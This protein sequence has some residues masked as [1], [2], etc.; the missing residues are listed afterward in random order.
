MERLRLVVACANGR[1]RTSMSEVLT[2][3]GHI[4]VGEAG[5][6]TST[7]VLTRNVRPDVVLLG[8][9][10][11]GEGGPAVA[12]ELLARNLAALVVLTDKQ[13]LPCA[14]NLVS[15][16]VSGCLLKPVS[17]EGL[18]FTIAIAARK[19]NELTQLTQ[20]AHIAERRLANRQLVEKAKGV[21][22]QREGV[23]EDEAYGQLRRLSMQT[24]RDLGTVAQ[25]VL[26]NESL[27]ME[28]SISCK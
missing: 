4:V 22:M 18:A 16:G 26:M 23:C 13:T 7:L 5:D 14:R 6:G 21:L 2:R 12:R 17:P 19:R 20:R 9:D 3:Y 15:A 10:L 28:N 1:D 11:P 25:A 8:L 27:R 24:R